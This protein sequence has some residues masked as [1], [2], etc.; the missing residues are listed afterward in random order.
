MKKIAVLFMIGFLGVNFSAMG[1]E[2]TKSTIFW[3]DR[4]IAQLEKMT[5]LLLEA[6]G[7]LRQRIESVA[8]SSTTVD[9][10]IKTDLQ[11]VLVSRLYD[12][13]T[14][15]NYLTVSRC[16]ECSQIR[17]EIRGNY[18]K[19]SRGIADEDY[20]R[21]KAAE[22]NVQGFLDIG[23]FMSQ[24]QLSMTL[25]AYEAKDGKI[26]FSEIITGDPGGKVQYTNGFFG[27]LNIPIEVTYT[28]TVAGERVDQ[29]GDGVSDK[30]TQQVEHSAFIFG[31][32]FAQ[33]ISES[34]L[35]SGTV[36]FL[37]D[38]NSNLDIRLSDGLDG[39]LVDGTVAYE[40]RFPGVRGAL[41][42]VL[43][44]GN[45]FVTPISSPVFV[46]FGLKATVGE[47]LTFN[48]YQLSFQ[49]A[50]TNPKTSGAQYVAMG[51]QF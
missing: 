21:T 2:Q 42:A 12:L 30:A 6:I 19:V 11:K 32:E 46:K 45:L 3:E 13:L 38:D 17:S 28:K 50:P 34:W 44:V 26:V 22:L 39:L 33:R 10:N 49:P 27:K 1:K 25:A 15:D 43:G 18:L 8:I 24:D 48:F 51:W 47:K 16:Q 40:W 9:E 35:F 36:A 37:T 4:E 41:D 31:V 20:R 7:R 5:P 23:I 14:R 29:N